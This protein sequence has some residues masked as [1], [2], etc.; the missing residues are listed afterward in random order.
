MIIDSTL[1]TII[2]VCLGVGLY[3]LRTSGLRA[4]K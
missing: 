4:G 3:L 1:G 2:L